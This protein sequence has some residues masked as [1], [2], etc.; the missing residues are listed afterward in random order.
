MMLSDAGE[1]PPRLEGESSP[2]ASES[3]YALDMSASEEG[4]LAKSPP[5]G[6]DAPGRVQGFEHDVAAELANLDI[7]SATTE[8]DSSVSVHAIR[9][10][11]ATNVRLRRKV[12]GLKRAMTSVPCGGGKAAFP[13]GSNMK[14]HIALSP[15][16]MCYKLNM[17]EKK[18]ATLGRVNKNLR[19]QVEVLS[20][21]GLLRSLEGKLKK[22]EEEIRMLRE[23]NRILKK[24]QR[25]IDRQAAVEDIVGCREENL[26]MCQLGEAHEELARTREMCRQLEQ[27][28]EASRSEQR[29]GGD[30]QRQRQRGAGMPSKRAAVGRNKPVQKEGAKTADALAGRLKVTEVERDG[31]KSKVVH[32]EQVLKRVRETGETESKALRLQVSRLQK[33]KLSLEESFG[34]EEKAM[35]LQLFQL[36]QVRSACE[37]LQCGR[38]KLKEIFPDQSVEEEARLMGFEDCGAAAQG[39]RVALQPVPPHKSSAGTGEMMVAHHQARRCVQNTTQ[40]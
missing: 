37:D 28:L 2:S 23:E 29:R 20:S 12:K 17:V 11:A 4:Q 14:H 38:R 5:P 27:M 31:L 36:R 6:F 1:W 22:R 30:R 3:G 18:A 25:E 32:L 15:A 8:Y 21:G 19:G 33:E 7:A 9:E 40:A 39:A 10:L 24:V 34:R 16:A 26:L 13:P 35:R